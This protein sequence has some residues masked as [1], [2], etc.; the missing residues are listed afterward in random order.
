MSKSSSVVYFQKQSTFDNSCGVCALNNLMGEKMF[1][2]QFLN[3]VCSNFSDSFI[4]PYKSIFGGD[5]DVTALISAL[6]CFE[7]NVRWLKRDE[8]FE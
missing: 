1:T 5:F 6:E 7:V 3:E 4:N 8:S 2:K